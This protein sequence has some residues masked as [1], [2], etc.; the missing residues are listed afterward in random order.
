MAGQEKI[1]SKMEQ[2]AERY[3][4]QYEEHMEVLESK[5]MLSKLRQVEYYDFWA[6]GKQLEAFEEWRDMC[7]E[8]GNLGQLGRIPNIAFDVITAVQGASILPALASVQPID[9]EQGI[10]YFK[11]VKSSDTRGSQTAGDVIVDP[12]TGTVTP[13]GYASNKIDPETLVGS[14]TATVL[15]Y[16]PTAAVTPIRKETLFI[17][18]RTSGGV[19]VSEGR[20]QGDGRIFGNGLSGTVNYTTGALVIDLIADPGNTNV[21][22]ARYQQNFELA[23]DI[24]QMET[25]LATKSILAHVYALKGTVGM[26]QSF[27]LRKRFGMIAED[28]LAKDLVQ[29][30]NRE[31][32]GDLIRKLRAQSLG[33]ETFNRTPPDTSIS[34]FEHKQLWKDSLAAAATN[35]LANAGRGDISTLVLGRKHAELVRTLPGFELLSDGTTLGAHIFGKIDGMTVIRVTETAVLGAL[36]GIGMWK[37]GGPFESACVYTPYM[38]LAVTDMLPEAPNPLVNMRAA[39]VWAGVDVLVPEYA[40]KFDVS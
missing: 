40:T 13:Q 38:P 29:E 14:T 5:S 18:E 31:I 21:I 2:D 9:E 37:G 15:Q 17:F 34:F 22:T 8:S 23:T 7:E 16:T 24:P 19:L 11:Q 3:F 20:D 32:G 26:L 1:I 12:R 39:A 25:S 28:M 33:S 10:V 36:E 6:L 4:N 27:A 30:I 35:L